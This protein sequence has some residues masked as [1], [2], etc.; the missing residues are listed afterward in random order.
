MNLPPTRYLL[1]LTV[2]VV[3]ASVTVLILPS[4]L[5]PAL[6]GRDAPT[7]PL[8]TLGMGF[9]RPAP[10]KSPTRAV[11][12]APSTGVRWIPNSTSYTFDTLNGS[13]LHG[14]FNPPIPGYPATLLDIPS[15]HEFVG[16]DVGGLLN[17]QTVYKYAFLF[18][19]TTGAEAGAIPTAPQP[20]AFAYNPSRGLLYEAGW[21]VSFVNLS[22][23]RETLT[24]HDSAFTNTTTSLDYDLKTDLLYVVNWTGVVAV[25]ATTGSIVSSLGVHSGV[26][27]SIVDP[28]TN[29]LLVADGGNSTVYVV[30]LSTFQVTDHF[31]T[32]FHGLGYDPSAFLYDPYNQ[33]IY[34]ADEGGDVTVIDATTYHLNSTVP[35]IYLDGYPNSLALNPLRHEVYV[36]SCGPFGYRVCAFYDTNSTVLN[37]TLPNSWPGYVAYD[38]GTEHLLIYNY[39]DSV[40]LF[41]GTNDRELAFSRIYA[42]YL[43]GAF[44]P[45]NGLEY[46]ATP[47]DCS[48]RG[49][50]TVLEPSARPHVVMT[51]PAGIGPSGV[52]YDPTD[53]R[54]FVTN[55]CSNSVTVIDA[56]NNTVVRPDLPVGKFPYGIAWNPVNDTVV[57]AN[58]NSQNLTVLNA[59]SLSTVATIALPI[60]N[61][62]G[63]AVDPVDHTVFVTDVNSRAVTV[64][65]ATSNTVKVNKVVVGSSPQGLLYDPQNGLVYVANGGSNNVTLLNGTTDRVMYSIDTAGGT[66]AL[67]LDPVDHLIFG[68]D[69]GGSRIVLIDTRRNLG[70]LPSLPASSTP[71]GVVYV[72]TSHQVD[73]FSFGTG[74]INVLAN[75]PS[76]S[77]FTVSPNVDEVGSPLALSVDPSN[78]TPPYDFTY[79]GLPTGCASV[80]APSLVC[81]PESTGT[82]AVTV[83]VTDSANYT[84]TGTVNVTV[85]PRIASTALT[86]TPQAIDLGMSPTFNWSVLDGV[87]PYHYA[88]SGL[89][90]GCGTLDRS[91]MV[92]TPTITGGF[93]VVGT[94]TDALGA[95]TTSATFL[96]VNAPPR[97]DALVAIPGSVSVNETVV[98]Q[99]SVSGGT[100]PRSFNYTGLPA[101][102]RFDNSSIV[103]CDP[104]IPGEY[105]VNLTMTD[106]VDHTARGQ[107]TFTV[108][109]AP[110]PPAPPPPQI[111]AFFGEPAQVTVGASVTFY[112]VVTGGET[113]YSMVFRGL[114]KGCTAPSAFSGQFGCVPTTAG[115][116][117]VE[118]TVSDG[119]GRNVTG[120]TNVS[121]L[122][123]PPTP[124]TGFSGLALAE[125]GLLGM[126]IGLA[127]AFM[128]LRFRGRW[129]S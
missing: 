1:W 36:G 14:A 113:P 12:P 119:L 61:P 94:A 48:L 118:V 16:G 81:I 87:A 3:A 50:V 82:F 114:P 98:L 45:D 18:N 34:S 124:A 31:S 108:N 56:S 43:G 41:N 117:S 104:T 91:W 39:N 122:P 83:T 35:E 11:A 47:P 105:L 10:V 120:S 76:I 9:E 100:A 112:T 54:I 33:Q 73:V 62:Y 77:R 106:A 69:A 99:A 88:Y 64:I 103:V 107:A 78:G 90:H 8:G 28:L 42:S 70:L 15:R 13:L 72:P 129:K 102:C 96:I 53:H 6:A 7:S 49:A 126:G 63:V 79:T 97:V 128:V 127:A 22:T 46:V 84:W 57:V 92:C 37:Y 74:A 121:V 125:T 38:P 116:Y 89:P 110:P 17:G 44:D 95:V 60:A 80:D 23:G 29:S 65:N 4:A 27:A 51:I 30:N 85:V 55:Y 40:Y 109:P 58:E 2:F 32:V 52:A 68:A 75:A 5:S 59:S 115:D 20:W 67:A 86:V 123:A 111:A 24:L 71:E 93:S 26:G 25:N 19:A 21:F 101:G 66:V